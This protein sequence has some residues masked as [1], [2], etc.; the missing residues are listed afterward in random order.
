MKNSELERNCPKCNKIIEYKRKNDCK[1]AN[2]KNS[3]CRS[4]N[5]KL[6]VFSKETREKISNANKGHVAWNKGIPKEEFFTHFNEHS[7]AKLKSNWFKEGDR[8]KNADFR[9]GKTLEEIFGK[10][11][12]NKIKF[13]NSNRVRSDLEKKQRD[14]SMRKSLKVKAAAKNPER[15]KKISDALKGKKQ[16]I[17][18]REKLSKAR[19]GL[20]VGDRNP[21]KRPEVKAKIRKS[22][23]KRL[24]DQFGNSFCPS[25]NKKGCAFFDQLAKETNTF[26]QHGGNIGEFYI[27]ELGYWVDGYDKE[28]NI[29]Y[30][31]DEKAHFNIDGSLKEKDIL[32]QQEIDL[33]LKCKFI[34]FK[35]S[36]YI[37]N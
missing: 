36:D 32:R 12:A 13:T 23:I 16:S 25:Y 10:D 2:K 4:C 35:E 37:K 21:S 14:A 8:P 22:I 9:K 34:R 17:E 33:Y 6:R 5:N 24:K 1:S 15:N 7:L 28:N 26:I 29:V 3:N 18:H 31:W 27:K 30:E 19:K 20:L 11:I